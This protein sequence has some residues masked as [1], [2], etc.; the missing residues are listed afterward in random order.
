MQCT[1]PQS[2]AFEQY[3][4]PS[5]ASLAS[6]DPNVCHA[7]KP[8]VVGEF[9]AQL[10]MAARIGIYQA[11]YDEILDAATDGLPAAG[12][13]TS[14]TSRNTFPASA[15]FSTTLHK[16]SCAHMLASSESS[17][18]CLTSRVRMSADGSVQASTVVLVGYS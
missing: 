16:V 11:I 7:D 5:S 13:F 1:L 2:A 15:S 4:P 17:A 3:M 18:A 12:A 9:G 8:V 10:P 6:Q 14:T